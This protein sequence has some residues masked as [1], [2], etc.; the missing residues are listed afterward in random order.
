V[1]TPPNCGYTRKEEVSM[2]DPA[3]LYDEDFYL[4]TLKMAEALRTGRFTELDTEH[5]A[6][7]IADMGKNNARELESRL[8]QVLEHLLK[9][10]LAKGLILE[11]NQSA[12]Q[13]SI[14]RQQDEL[15]S[16]FH[17]S[18]SLRFRIDA[19]LIQKCYRHAAARVATEYKVEPP[20]ECP[21]SQEEIL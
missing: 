5:L 12:W 19:D 4:W 14:L 18:P 6:E 16:L 7:E 10:K 2:P 9:L 8:T 3:T 20:A 17:Q 21:F 13:A 15:D 11:Y 1:V